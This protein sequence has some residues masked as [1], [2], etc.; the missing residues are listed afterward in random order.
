MTSSLPFIEIYSPKK[1]D[2]LVDNKICIN[3]LKT[4]LKNNNLNNMIITGPNGVGKT[5]S[6]YCLI[7]QY[8]K[9]KKDE[10]VLELN[11][12]DDRSINII[13]NKILNFAKLKHKETEYKK[14]VILDECDTMIDLSQQSLKQIIENCTST[15][16]ILICNN[17]ENLI[18]SLHSR[19]INLKFK[20]IEDKFVKERLKYICDNQKINI[21][22]KGL[23]GLVFIS[24]GDMRQAINNL[25]SIHNCYDIINYENIFKICEYPHPVIIN[26]I[27]DLLIDNKF[28]ESIKEIEKLI[29]VG[30]SSFDIIYIIFK[31][32]Q[33]KEN[34]EKLKK[35]EIIKE[36]S[37]IHLSILNGLDNKLQLLYLIEKINYII[38]K[39]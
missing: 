1:L 9:I 36:I 38:N 5:S 25:E 20:K 35:I 27:F 17:S 8:Y 15:K 30:Y 22:D 26:N 14:I 31:I 7:N 4:M 29:E 11:A 3:R 13:K 10:L 19:C 39:N 28:N 33:E 18:E 34:I 21:T 37:I 23:D 24:N 32:I 12:A 6:I 16:F 2:D